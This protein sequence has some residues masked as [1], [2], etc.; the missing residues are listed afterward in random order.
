MA[1]AFPSMTEEIIGC[2]ECIICKEDM[3]DPKDLPCQHTFCL[4]C[5]EKVVETNAPSRRIPCPVCRDIWE[6]PPNGPTELKTH[7]LMNQLLNIKKKRDAGSKTK[8][9]I[10]EKHPD[11]P[12][13]LFC[14]TDNSILC[15][16]CLVKHHFGHNY[17]EIAQGAEL[18]EMK[19][20]TKIEASV[21]MLRKRADIL[22]VEKDLL[23]QVHA[24]RLSVEEAIK[25]AFNSI[26]KSIT[27]HQNTE[28]DE[29]CLRNSI[30]TKESKLAKL[31]AI[32]I[33][34][35]HVDIIRI[36][37]TL[38]HEHE[39]LPKSFNNQAAIILALRYKPSTISEGHVV[40]G[41]LA[42]E[43]QPLHVPIGQLTPI[44][45][46]ELSSKRL[47][48]GELSSGRSALEDLPGELINKQTT[49]EK[50][51][52]VQIAHGEFPRRQLHSPEEQIVL[53][54]YFPGEHSP[55]EPV[56]RQTDPRG[57][58]STS[59]EP[60]FELIGPGQTP[61]RQ[62]STPETLDPPKELVLNISDQR[63]PVE[64]AWN[65]GPGSLPPKLTIRQ[66]NPPGQPPPEQI[67]KGELEQ[68]ELIV[69]GQLN[70]EN[71]DDI[72]P[73][74]FCQ[75]TLSPKQPS[76]L[77]D[78]SLGQLAAE[79]NRTSFKSELES[80]VEQNLFLDSIQPADNFPIQLIDIAPHQVY[81]DQH[82]QRD[83]APEPRHPGQLPKTLSNN[84]KCLARARAS[85][86]ERTPKLT[87]NNKT[88]KEGL[89][90]LVKTP[91]EGRVEKANR[92]Q[93]NTK[94]AE[95]VH[96]KVPSESITTYSNTSKNNTP[97]E[98]TESDTH[99]TMIHARGQHRSELDVYLE[100]DIYTSNNFDHERIKKS[101]AT[102][103]SP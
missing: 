66:I 53:R 15:Y 102:D 17:I 21:K 50:L 69:Q 9:K 90:R 43:K 81:S 2:I 20:R 60:A 16:E 103:K 28:I 33:E 62:H 75:D 37:E 42:A 70:H 85:N 56:P 52:S 76:S 63:T 38:D 35:G 93:A 36:C 40:F 71:V 88:S 7:R 65:I 6:V 19:L 5:I 31:D 18:H 57:E 32:K 91:D 96:S 25:E 73:A 74:D 101:D 54:Q 98:S 8:T 13:K 83:L 27:K 41:K 39:G 100:Q 11:E 79:Q 86:N 59:E 23:K 26:I 84:S 89:P 64:Y 14:K 97:M 51:S 55:G 49:P 95:A 24:D 48:H 72:Y 45:L 78:I 1:Q 30:A 87:T 68:H 47:A 77:D 82:F 94:D 3:I 92:P 67:T 61:P 44:Q 99:N 58:F 29:E 22:E 46:E 80:L 4:K 10:C 34:S 12:L